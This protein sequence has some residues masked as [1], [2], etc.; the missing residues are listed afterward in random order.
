[1]PCHAGRQ[2]D[3]QTAH[4][5]LFPRLLSHPFPS[6]HCCI[7]RSSL[8]FPSFFLLHFLLSLFFFLFPLLLFLLPS[9]S[10]SS[11]VDNAKRNLS[12]VD[13][14]ASVYFPVACFHR[15]FLTITYLFPCPC[16]CPVAVAALPLCTV[17]AV[18]ITVKL[19]VSILARAATDVHTTFL[20]PCPV[21]PVKG[22]VLLQRSLHSSRRRCNRHDNNNNSG[23]SN[24]S[25]TSPPS[26]PSNCSTWPSK[27]WQQ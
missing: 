20:D 2:A 1:M 6:L 10:P 11:H 16:S 5:F 23:S 22:R 14:S 13:P 7:A 15:Q 8:L 9:H 25:F 4:C 12:A 19:W 17:A 26:F 21:R 3:R 18:A 24:N 27:Q